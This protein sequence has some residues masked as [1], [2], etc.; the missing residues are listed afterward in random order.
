[1]EVAAMAGVTPAVRLLGPVRISK[2]DA[3]ATSHCLTSQFP[4]LRSNSSNWSRFGQIRAASV[5][6][7]DEEGASPRNNQWSRSGGGR[8]RGRGGG[9]GGGRGRG[10]GYGSSGRG[11][12][13]VEE[14]RS[15]EGRGNG[16]NRYST[17][18]AGRNLQHRAP[19]E[20][21]VRANRSPVS[22]GLERRGE[23]EEAE[24]VSYE[25]S[26]SGDGSYQPGGGQKS[27]MARIVEKLRA[28][29]NENSTSSRMD[30]NKNRPATETSAFLPRPGQ[31]A[32]PGLDRRW[33][34]ADH[35]VPKRASEDEEQLKQDARFPWE[36]DEEEGEEGEEV[37][38]KVKKIRSPSMAELTIPEPELKRLRTLGLQV[39]G[40]LKIGRLGVTPGIV[41]AIHDRWRSCEVAKVRCD[42]PLSMNMKKAHEDLERLTGGLVIWRSGSA[43][44][45]YRGKD[46][47]P[48]FVR[49]REEREERERRKLLSLGLEEDDEREQLTE[50][51][52]AGSE[53]E[54]ELSKEEE[55]SDSI[56]D[57]SAD[58]PSLEA[59]EKVD[60]LK[61]KQ[62]AELQM[63]EE[64]LDG[65]GPRYTDWTGKRP[66]PVDADLL[67]SPD[68]EFK[69]PFRLL[70]YGVKPKLNNF[71]MTELRRLARP[72]PPHFVL[73]KNRGLGGLAA[74]IAKLW[75]K[76]EIV[77]IGVKR[78]VQNT[79][80]ERM[81][82]ELKRLT[83]GTLLARDKEFIVF[84][85][86]K[87]FL[88]PAVQ[89]VLEERDRMTKA[90][91]EEEERLR[92]GGRKRPLQVVEPSKAGTLEE[93]METRASWEAWQN[94]DEA[95]KERIKQRK[96]KRFQAMEK[97]RSKMR[98]AVQKKERA[99][100]ELAKIDAKSGLADTP[101]DKEHLSDGER[102]MYRKLGLKMK[103]FLLLGRRGV[104][105]GTVEN[106]HLH[107]KYRELVKILVKAPLPEAE[108][109]A[110]MLEAESGGILV[111]IV[112]T[113]KGQAMIMYRG[114]NYQRPSEL[115]PRHL[116]TKRQA[117]K[118]SLEMQRMQSLEKH[119]GTLEKEIEMMQAG[120]S[121]MEDL[122][123]LED[124][125]GAGS[126]LKDL[127]DDDLEFDGYEYDDEYSVYTPGKPKKGTYFQAEPLSR[128]ERHFLRQQIPLMVGRTANFNIGKTTIYEDLAKSICSYFDIHPF[129]KIGVKGR[130]KGT[131]VA[132]VVE[133]IEES[134]GAVLL[135]TEPS[136]L[137]FYRGWPA[138]E[139]RPDLAALKKEKEDKAEHESAVKGLG[140][141]ADDESN[142]SDDDDFGID[143]WNEDDWEEAGEDD[144][145]EQDEE[146][147]EEEER[148]HD[149]STGGQWYSFSG[150][151]SDYTTDTDVDELATVPSPSNEG[152]SAE[153]DA[154]QNSNS[155]E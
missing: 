140:A 99:L 133:Q 114:K 68:F 78:G 47:V 41:E 105:G 58:E 7:V 65:L 155:K 75:E 76:S 18:D 21:G 89:V 83:G 38:G 26:R 27:A 34:N 70:P 92:L 101:L 10:S 16:G 107:W 87:D 24:E 29:G 96:M 137:I 49:E 131:S 61:A 25:D 79:S 146:D 8:G 154:K 138:G 20:Q 113:S 57:L 150:G 77:K 95:R 141:D 66:I 50:A 35:P 74:A 43:A 142:D 128:K 90:L 28:I 102:Y 73:G 106:M 22:R 55:D 5:R 11:G 31:A 3:R 48:P 36:K 145:D 122:E 13:R 121:K 80:N 124:E 17:Y 6:E 98:F 120:L 9:R 148:S 139:E 69:R 136:K 116:L 56:E 37:V 88:P 63:M 108:R 60:Y 117:L 51:F 104:F 119:I 45:V 85:R 84:F 72:I 109:I 42:A 153:Q 30:F 97:I 112:T 71:E 123:D 149:E 103:A 111:D 12:Q 15:S 135:S 91:L 132:S 129:V 32:Q 64:I 54:L 62:E 39:Q 2:L 4:S 53:E 40:R 23:A 151:E 81:A 127:E 14:S 115:R 86:G 94:S 144:E 59:S 125:E 118:R 46:Y 33:S 19:W 52:D 134:T 110:K 1:M 152:F 82:E 67:L 126:N 143:A 93:A 100:T 44:V 147:E 130:P